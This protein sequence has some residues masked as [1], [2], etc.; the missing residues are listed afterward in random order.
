MSLSKF[1]VGCG[2]QHEGRGQFH[3]KDCHKAYRKRKRD[4]AAAKKCRFCGRPW[5]TERVE[6]WKEFKEWKRMRQRLEDS[7]HTSVQESLHV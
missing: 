2:V 6:E 3:S 5:L 7:A 4:E 1:C